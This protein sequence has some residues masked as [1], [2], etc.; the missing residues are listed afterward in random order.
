MARYLHRCS[1]GAPCYYLD[2]D[3]A[4]NPM[5]YT[6]DGIW[7]GYVS[8][9]GASVYAPD[10]RLLFSISDGYFRDASG[11]VN[12]SRCPGSW[13]RSRGRQPRGR[14]PRRRRPG[15][16]GSGHGGRRQEGY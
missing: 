11:A 13:R 10:R 14:R 8:S 4:G 7:A 6:V 9:D 5:L 2:E 3:G 12:A 16:P 1:D 15:V